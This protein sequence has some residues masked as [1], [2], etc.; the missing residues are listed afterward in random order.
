MLAIAGIVDEI[1]SDTGAH[2]S[3]QPRV[4]DMTCAAGPLGAK[5]GRAEQNYLLLHIFRI[6][7]SPTIYHSRPRL[8]L[9]E[10]NGVWKRSASLGVIGRAEMRSEEHTSE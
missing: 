8:N 9:S 1:G 10:R 6:M 7:Q 4:T 2:R 5:P 3:W